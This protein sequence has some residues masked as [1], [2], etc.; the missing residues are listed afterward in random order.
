M[1]GDFFLIPKRNKKKNIENNGTS[2]APINLFVSSHLSRKLLRKSKNHLPDAP[3]SFKILS[4]KSL[5]T[6]IGARYQSFL[7]AG[8]KGKKKNKNKKRTSSPLGI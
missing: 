2:A 8:V 6:I 7:Q 1:C 3:T 5:H 4:E